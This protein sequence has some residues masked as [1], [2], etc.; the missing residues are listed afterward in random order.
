MRGGHGILA[1][2][3]GRANTIARRRLL[4]S[5]AR[6]VLVFW[7]R[8]SLCRPTLLDLDV[9]WMELTPRFHRL[10]PSS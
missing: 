9:G 7:F 6:Y 3:E 1:E 5:A 10:V 8:P 2:I 4:P